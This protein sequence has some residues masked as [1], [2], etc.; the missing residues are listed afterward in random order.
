MAG[1]KN[2]SFPTLPHALSD[3]PSGEG[4]GSPRKKESDR[5]VAALFFK[6]V[7]A[8]KKDGGQKMHALSLKRRGE[9]KS[10]SGGQWRNIM[11]GMALKT[12]TRHV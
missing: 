1:R 3:C 11:N 4:R 5:R 6:D 10:C 8:I 12:N 2:E 9:R 7:E